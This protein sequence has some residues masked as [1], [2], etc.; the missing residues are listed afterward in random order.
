MKTVIINLENHGVFT[1]DLEDGGG[2][3]SSNLHYDAETYRDA[4]DSRR[5][6]DL[7]EAMVDAIESL[8][9]GHAC[10]GIDVTSEAYKEG[11]ISALGGMANARL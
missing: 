5:Q 7:Y 11:L 6:L 4:F 2:C 9:L 3:C 1:L 10:A 8:V